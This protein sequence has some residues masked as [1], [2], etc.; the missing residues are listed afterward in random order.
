[1]SSGPGGRRGQS[2]RRA[3]CSIPL[4]TGVRGGS[5]G[6]R[7]GKREEGRGRAY[8]CRRGGGGGRAFPGE[9]D[10]PAEEE[11]GPTEESRGLSGGGRGSRTGGAGGSGRR[12]GG[13]HC[14][15][16]AA[17]RPLVLAADRD[18]LPQIRN[19]PD[20]RWATLTHTH[21]GETTISDFAAPLSVLRREAAKIPPPLGVGLQLCTFI[22]YNLFHV[23][24][25]AV[26]KCGRGRRGRQSSTR[27]FRIKVDDYPPQRSRVGNLAPGPNKPDR[28]FHL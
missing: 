8:E 3:R 7:Y 5:G 27:G 21:T 23:N 1:M 18:P 25:H 26:T 16:Q 12:L 14:W 28:P 9:G 24:K 10:R 17:A 11:R 19:R 4:Q 15:T 20:P 13:G 2:Y 6:G 22:Y